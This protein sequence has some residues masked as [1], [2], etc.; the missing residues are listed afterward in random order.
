MLKPVMND[1]LISIDGLDS[2]SKIMLIKSFLEIVKNY[3]ELIPVRFTISFLHDKDSFIRETSTKIL[4]YIGNKVPIESTDALIN[5]SLKDDEWIVRDAAVLSLGRLIN[6]FKDNEE[7][8]GKLVM[9]LDDKNSWVK[10]S[11]MNLLSSI[12]GLD[13]DLIPFKFVE[14]NLKSEDPK[15]REGLANLLKIFGFTRIDMIFDSILLLL[16]DESKD[17]RNNMINSMVSI[18]QEKGLADMLS[19]LLQNLSDEGS[20]TSQQSIAIILGRTARY[21]EEKIKKR[22]ISLLKIRCEASQDPIICETLNK[23]KED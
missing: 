16:G 7:I 23:L 22:I 2:N 1:L 5:F 13:P 14:K 21:E 19:K 10:R 4:G 17:V 3:P 9:L 11:V 15:I 20:I 6:E 12:S 8:I 18:I